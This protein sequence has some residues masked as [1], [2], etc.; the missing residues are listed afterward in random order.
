MLERLAK[1]L[2]VDLLREPRQVDLWL[3]RHH[4]LN[5]LFSLGLAVIP[6][7]GHGII[8][9]FPPLPERRQLDFTA[10]DWFREARD[11]RRLAIGKPTL[12]RAA[13]QP[14]IVIAAPRLDAAGRVVAIVA[15]VTALDTPGFLDL[16]Q[17]S[18]LGKT[19][20]F[21]LVSPRDNLF[22][23]ASKPE[24][25]LKPLPPPGVNR[26]HDAAMGGFRGTGITVNAYG[27]E[28][29]ASF[30]SVPAAD[31]FVVARLPTAE[32]FAPIEKMRSRYMRNSVAIGLLIIAVLLLFLRHTFRP[33][34]RA[35]EQ[36]RLMA[37]GKAPLAPLPVVRRD[38]VGE[39]AEGFNYLLEKLRESEAR[40]AHLAHHDAL[41]GLPN[42]LSFLAHMQKGAALAR[43][44]DARLALLFID[45]DGFKPVNDRYGHEVGDQLLQQV[46]AR[47]NEGVRESDTIAR[48][49]G[50]E[51]VLLLTDVADSGSAAA[52]AEK[53]IARLSAPYCVEAIQLNIGA[54]IGIALFPDDGEDVGALIAQAD[55]AMYDAKRGG[56]GCCRFAHR[57]E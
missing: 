43:R 36:M 21:L 19:G 23:A 49:G 50:D 37:D 25:R 56:R 52:I 1:D 29:L 9:D 42:R 4:A 26:L 44:Q 31:W 47:L 46:A 8:A 30:A 48:F 16:I 12:G 41:T 51:F 57:R 20:G 38:E 32:A 10:T 6:P 17:D 54:S 18:Q 3:S 39:M 7:D 22:V 35:A 34:K 40:M 24:M 2:P 11:K 15:G 45:L 28:N 14:V 13:H 5:P 33:M 55:A 53:I 27:V